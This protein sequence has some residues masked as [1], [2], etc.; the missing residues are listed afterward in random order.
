MNDIT[1]VTNKIYVLSNDKYGRFYLQDHIMD[2]RKFYLDEIE[3]NKEDDAQVRM[4]SEL[5]HMVCKNYMGALVYID[6]DCRV[7]VRYNDPNL[8]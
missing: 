7:W 6:K 4:I 2:N 5:S 1:E 3:I 8:M